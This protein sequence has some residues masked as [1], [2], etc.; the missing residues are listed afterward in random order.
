MKKSLVV[1]ALAL[2]LSDQIQLRGKYPL[3]FFF[4]DEGFGSLDRNALEVAMATLERLR[5][6][7]LTIGI[8]GHVEDLQQRMPRRLAVTPPDL[9]GKGSRVR[10]EIQ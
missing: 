8:I 10:I 9:L 5:H 1:L 4:L 3:E 6:D 7:R 2:A